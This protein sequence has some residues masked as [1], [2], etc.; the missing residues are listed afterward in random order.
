MFIGHFAPAFIAASHPKAPRLGVLFIAAQLVDIAFFPFVLLGIEHMRIVP[1]IT[2]MNPMDLY[3]M[4]YTHSLLGCSLWA[5]GL[6]AA[7]FAVTKNHIAAALGF[8]VVLSHWLL[9]VLVH[10]ADMTLLG[11]E[12]K[13]GIGLWNHPMIAIPLELGITAAAFGLYLSQ[14]RNKIGAKRSPAYLLGGALLLVQ[15]YNWF[16]PPPTAMDASLPISAMA[17]F[18]LFIWLAFRLDVSRT[19]K[20]AGENA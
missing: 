20:G 9:D 17:A 2:A 14:S 19:N 10:R 8:L 13:L 12:P 15:L 6:A 18:G 3:H 7:L 4:P 11:N 1:G 5:L 16:A